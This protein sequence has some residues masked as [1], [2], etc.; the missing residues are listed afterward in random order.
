[1]RKLFAKIKTPF[2]GSLL[3]LA[4]IGILLLLFMQPW[5]R[6]WITPI[7]DVN[8]VPSR[9]SLKAGDVQPGSAWDLIQRASVEKQKISKSSRSIR[10]KF[11]DE[12]ERLNLEPW[13]DA[14]F[15]ASVQYL[16]L[17]RAVMDLIRQACHATE[18]QVPDY[19][20]TNMIPPYGLDLI[21][22]PS[23]FSASAARKVST[24][25]YGGAFAELN[26]L[27][28]YADA[29]S[30]GST[31]I[32]RVIEA[33]N[34]ITALRDIRRIALQHTLPGNVAA[35]TIHHLAMLDQ[36]MEPWAETMRVEESR[37]AREIKWVLD[38]G[39]AHYLDDYPDWFA[40]YPRMGAL[41]TGSW[42]GRMKSDIDSLY[43]HFIELS[44]KPYDRASWRRLD[45]GFATSSDDWHL[46]VSMR[47]PAG[48]VLAEM[49]LR[50][51]ESATLTHYLKIADLRATEVVLAIL[52]FEKNESHPPANLSEL[53]P[54]YLESIPSDPYDGKP[55]RYK[56]K[57]DGT[58]I[59]YSIGPDQMDDGGLKAGEYSSFDS[60][61]DR[62]YPSTE[63]IEAKKKLEARQKAE[64]AR[65][66]K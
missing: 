2:W 61:G 54:R 37:V 30:R 60:T 66:K 47:D 55:L 20:G 62:V 28:D 5:R 33:G 40:K 42:P 11:S 26:A 56:V 57:S 44:A 51:L 4:G 3:F 10:N 27:M 14:A 46:W 8:F 53:V 19:D 38:P 24:G 22:V 35:D 50:G 52:Q 15:P 31:I 63:V 16:D 32:M 9:P 13:T 17:N 34:E 58:W 49:M 21:D 1:M 29:Y 6:R 18:K 12:T 64:E 25:D 48:Y 39:S 59:V 43:A 45:A 41:V 7:R 23:L 65:K 36:T